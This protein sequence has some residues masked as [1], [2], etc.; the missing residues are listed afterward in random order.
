MDPGS[1]YGIPS[2]QEEED[3]EITASILT[4]VT[5]AAPPRTAAATMEITGDFTVATTADTSYK[6]ESVVTSP[7][8]TATNTDAYKDAPNTTFD[9]TAE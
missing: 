8:T 1:L 2:K 3:E 6:T 9:E 5:Y 4:Q 7:G